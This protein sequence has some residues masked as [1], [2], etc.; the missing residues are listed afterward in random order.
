MARNY[1]ARSQG[2]DAM[3][4]INAGQQGWEDADNRFKSTMATFATAKA[5]RQY[6]DGDRRGAARTFAGSGMI[7]QARLLEGDQRAADTRRAAAEKAQRD[8]AAAAAKAQAEA[9]IKILSRM[10]QLRPDAQDPRIA[11][12]MAQGL[13]Y[14]RA[15][16]E[17]RKAEFDRAMPIFESF[18]T[19]PETIAQ[20]R[21]WPSSNF[22]DEGLMLATGE[23]QDAYDKI[24]GDLKSGIY[25]V[26]GGKVTVLQEPM[27]QERVLK[28]EDVLIG[29]DG[30]VKARGNN[31]VF[32]PPGRGRGVAG[33]PPPPSGWR[34]AGQ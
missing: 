8:E 20:L 32:A 27:P 5:G 30:V 13:P 3:D 14:E 29:R 19:P 10:A 21:Q 2:G 12:F 17:F 31:K 34:P 6:A 16:E 11:Q 25:G 1:F 26:K 4:I 15:L 24:G 33:L 7:D 9:G 18:G 23:M 28:P 22:S